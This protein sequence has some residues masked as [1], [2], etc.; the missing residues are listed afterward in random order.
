MYIQYTFVTLIEQLKTA[1]IC[2][3]SLFSFTIFTCTNT[4]RKKSLKS[5]SF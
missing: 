3:L 2:T 4:E 1:K 5:R